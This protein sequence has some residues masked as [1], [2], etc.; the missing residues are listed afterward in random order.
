MKIPKLKCPILLD[1]NS[2]QGS[3]YTSDEFQEKIEQLKMRSSLSGVGCCYDNAVVERFFGSLKHEWLGSTRMMKDEQLEEKIAQYMRYYNM[4][5]LHSRNNGM[6]PFA[7]ENSQISNKSVL[8]S[9][10]RT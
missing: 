1:Q 9:L 7:F 8:F 2:D 4:D 10:T 3:Q 6:S 5:R